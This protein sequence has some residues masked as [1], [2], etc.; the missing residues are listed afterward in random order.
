MGTVVRGIVQFAWRLVWTE[1]AKSLVKDFIIK[2]LRA[3]FGETMKAIEE[4]PRK[5]WDRIRGRNGQGS[6]K[7]PPEGSEPDPAAEPEDEPERPAAKPAEPIIV[8]PPAAPD[9]TRP[10]AR[11]DPVD[12]PFGFDPEFDA[13]SRL[14]D[15]L[16]DTW[17]DHAPADWVRP[18]WHRADWIRMQDQSLRARTDGWTAGLRLPQV[19]AELMETSPLA[20]A[21]GMDPQDRSMQLMRPLLRPSLRPQ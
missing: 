13:D 15:R 20:L 17:H 2:P 3:N 14:R 1:F 21:A 6:E 5:L 10:P 9:P 18:D 11:P 7:T 4:F 16:R 12:R 8:N 19:R